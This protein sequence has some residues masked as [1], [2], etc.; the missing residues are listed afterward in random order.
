MW[1]ASQ[2]TAQNLPPGQIMK[3]FCFINIHVYVVFLTEVYFVC[4]RHIVFV[5]KLF[6]MKI[7]V[8]KQSEHYKKVINVSMF[9]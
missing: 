2:Y 6:L 3:T 5:E 7:S 1:L 4:C 8:E 9:L